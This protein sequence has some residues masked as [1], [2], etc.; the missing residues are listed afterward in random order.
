M[1]RGN[2]FVQRIVPFAQHDDPLAVAGI[3]D[4]LHGPPLAGMPGCC[5]ANRT[6]ILAAGVYLFTAGFHFRFFVART[7][8]VAYIVYTGAELQHA[9]L[10]AVCKLHIKELTN[11]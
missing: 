1:N 11:G 9:A 5:Q 3:F 2:L 8:A 6:K 7:V 4:R 10:C